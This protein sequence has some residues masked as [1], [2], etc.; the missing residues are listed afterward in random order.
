M[1]VRWA[2]IFFLIIGFAWSLVYLTGDW[3][4]SLLGLHSFR[5]TQT[6]ITTYWFVQEGFRIDYQTPVLGP[7]W[8]IPFEFPFYQAL[9]AVIAHLTRLP[10][11]A[12]GRAVSVLF[13]LAT[14][15]PLDRILRWWL[16]DWLERALVLFTLWAT[17][18]NFYWA[19]SFMMES[20]ALFFCLL[21]LYWA[22]E[23]V[24]KGHRVL[25][26]LASIAGT[27]GALQKITVFVIV[28]VPT[29]L[30]AGKAFCQNKS[31]NRYLRLVWFGVLL[32]IPILITIAW[33]HYADTLK[34]LSPWAT[35][36]TSRALTTWNFGTLQQRV[37][38]DVWKYILHLDKNWGMAHGRWPLAAVICLVI[39]I[40][41][42]RGAYRYEIFAL[43]CGYLA[44]PLVFTNLFF[45]HEYYHYENL[46]FLGLAFGLSSY[47]LI[48][49]VTASRTRQITALA[50]CLGLLSLLALRDYRAVWEMRCKIV[51]TS[52]AVAQNLQPL[53]TAV[54][55]GDVLLIYAPSWDP[56]QAYYAQRK[57]ITDSNNLGLN[58]PNLR[59][60]L[61]HLSPGQRVGAMIIN[62]GVRTTPDFVAERLQYFQLS[63]F[64]IWT[65]WGKAYVRVD[66]IQPNRHR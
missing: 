37:S 57:A 36:F 65:R 2:T 29:L 19:N 54:P 5:Q 56:A 18:I 6:A 23:F 59:S 22:V 7:P 34:S 9:V 1:R 43:L 27:I 13:A 4:R 47:S 60:L 62:D 52:V 35:S 12:L 3:N 45:V 41:L 44:G 46:F 11:D 33:T 40:G 51:P 10:L 20:T 21:F 31:A 61:D 32:V 55:N 64:P 63:P 14:L 49:S 42:A 30:L 25:V 53:T 24:Q 17:P 66:T 58:D 50:L 48:R 38:V 8:S 39:I 26:L 15:W 16:P 28:S